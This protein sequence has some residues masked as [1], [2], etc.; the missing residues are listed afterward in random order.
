M[1]VRSPPLCGSPSLRR[2]RPTPWQAAGEQAGMEAR[3]TKAPRV[4]ARFS[5]SLA[6][7]RLR[8]NQEKVRSTTQ[9]RGKTTKPFLSSLRLTIPMRSRG[10]LLPQLQLV[11]RCSRCRPRSPPRRHRAGTCEDVVDSRT[12]RKAVAGQ[13]TPR[14]AGAQQ[15][16]RQ[17]PPPMPRTSWLRTRRASPERQVCR[18]QQCRA[19]AR[20]YSNPMDSRP[21][22]LA[23]GM[24]YKSSAFRGCG[25]R[26]MPISST[27]CVSR[28]PG[29]MDPAAKTRRG[30]AD[31]DADRGEHR[32]RNRPAPR[33]AS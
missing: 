17:C 22:R 30:F 16:H 14:A 5:K 11:T 12:W 27:A 9:R 26:N 6:R 15:I 7:R 24:V 32:V 2:A 23:E 18:S 1:K 13:I 31:H 10:F 29:L 19:T 25:E 4:S 8:P 20:G 33:R 3:A 28:L 21:L